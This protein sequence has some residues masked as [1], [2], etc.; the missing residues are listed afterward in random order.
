MDPVGGWLEG[1]TASARGEDLEKSSGKVAVF[2][3]SQPSPSLA[4]GSSDKLEPLSRPAGSRAYSGPT[5]VH[6]FP[7]GPGAIWPVRTCASSCRGFTGFT[8]VCR[9]V[10]LATGLEIISKRQRHHQHVEINS[11]LTQHQP[12][13]APP[14]HVDCT[15]RLRSILIASLSSV[16]SFSKLHTFD[17]TPPITSKSSLASIPPAMR[18]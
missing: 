17:S 7:V 14:K 18:L 11:F 3:P 4:A 12:S 13:S 16:L 2:P 15:P 9:G 10:P 1:I 8:G 5:L 6:P